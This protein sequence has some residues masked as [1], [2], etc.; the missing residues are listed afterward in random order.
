M[1]LTEEQQSAVEL[2]RTSRLLLI[3]GGPGSGKTT[4]IKYLVAAVPGTLLVAPTGC[5]ADRLSQATGME[6]ST[7]S[8]IL[9]TKDLG[10]RY[11]GANV[12]LDEAAMVSKQMLTLLMMLGPLRLALVG[13][14]HQLPC[15]T[16]K[17]IF[18]TLIAC[19]TIPVVHL[20]INHRQKNLASALTTMVRL[21]S[22]DEPVTL[23]DAD[24]SFKVIRCNSDRTAIDEGVRWFNELEGYAQVL[25]T[26]NTTC[27]LINER[28]QGSY[29]RRVICTKNYKVNS[30][31]VVANGVTGWV[32]ENGE[33]IG[34]SNDFVDQ[35]KRGKFATNYAPA[36]CITVHKCQGQEFSE[37][38]IIVLR[39]WNRPMS[40][41]LIY[42]AVSRF[43][44][45]VIVIGT[46]ET[47][48]AAWTS[49]FSLIPDEEMIRLLRG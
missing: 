23:P 20:T 26:T 16:G 27:N 36:R 10:P 45:G 42:T 47:L 46:D 24:A 22:V 39:H 2:F 33:S 21:L 40:R 15:V 43:A 14:A 1:E 35:R 18:H 19:G 34:Y 7:L 11:I 31:L 28:T 29:S 38:G 37:T 9:F 32:S 12:I 13:D 4:L 48:R 30:V 44:N 8:S 49:S 3:E 17:P 41:E 25:G 6:V 5:A